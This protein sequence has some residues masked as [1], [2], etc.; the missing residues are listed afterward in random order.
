MRVIS[1]PAL[2]GRMV[3]EAGRY[4]AFAFEKGAR[5]RDVIRDERGRVVGAQLE[6]E[7]GP[8]EVRADLIVGCDGRGS[9][10]R[11]RGCD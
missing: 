9:P 1:Q 6:T 4:P 10:V 2:L 5:L 8:R 3:E 11:A 7:G